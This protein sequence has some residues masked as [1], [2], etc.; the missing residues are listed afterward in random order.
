MTAM[1]PMILALLVGVASVA[2]P[3]TAAWAQAGPSTLEDVRDQGILYF[4]KK[5]YKQAKGALDRAYKM[6][7]GKT[8]FATLYYRSQA[9]FKLLFLETAFQ[10]GEAAEKAAETKRHKQRIGEH[11]A[12]MRQL[13]GA[14]TLV[15]AKGETNKKG[16]IYFEAQTGIINRAK[17]KRFMSIR[18]RFR[19][20]DI[21]LPITVYL[22]WGKYTANQV[23]F[24]LR[25]G[26][27]APR[28]EIFL[29]IDTAGLAK[30]GGLSTS[31]WVWIGV[32]AAVV[33]GGAVA[34]VLA[35]EE[36][37]PI[38]RRDVNFFGLG[39]R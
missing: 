19:S 23:P 39:G 30:G 38:Q 31:T 13:Y 9:S 1:R 28:L 3:V 34:T 14:V 27:P 18:E 25:Q 6:P 20:T 24:E 5:L 36:P 21:S 32:G 12:E 10:M 37:D 16:R 15:A 26:E 11:L 35:L 7:G 8:D 33:A 2:A 4:K 22:P 29:Q 17:K